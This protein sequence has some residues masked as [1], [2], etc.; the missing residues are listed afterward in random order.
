[1]TG[2]GSCWDGLGAFEVCFGSAACYHWR[3]PPS[4]RR[5]SGKTSPGWRVF[6]FVLICM[7]AWYETSEISTPACRDSRSN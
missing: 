7:P 3:A 6:L 5:V 4:L 1:M 2:C